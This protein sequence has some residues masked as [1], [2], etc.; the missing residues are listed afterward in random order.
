MNVNNSRD[1]DG[2][3]YTLLQSSLLTINAVEFAL[4]NTTGMTLNIS[5]NYANGSSHGVGNTTDWFNNT[6]NNVNYLAGGTL[7]LINPANSEISKSYATIYNNSYL[8][9]ANT[10]ISSNSDFAMYFVV[11]G[12]TPSNFLRLNSST[13]QVVLLTSKFGLYAG[14]D[15]YVNFTTPITNWSVFSLTKIGSIMSIYVDGI[16]INSVSSVN[17]SGAYAAGSLFS[18]QAG[19]LF[20]H[21]SIFDNV[22]HNS[23]LVSTLSNELK[24]Y[25][26]I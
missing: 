11:K 9:G 26:I 18:N 23:T 19:V 15:K 5:P 12:P 13:I 7:A 4:S 16:F 20:G 17:T 22:S 1:I 24:S 10:I 6:V 25:Y 8:I 14:S 3:Y 21:M 2:F